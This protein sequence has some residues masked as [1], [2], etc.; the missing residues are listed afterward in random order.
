MT[1]KD[2]ASDSLTADDLD[3]SLDRLSAFA[4]ENNPTARKEILLAKA[5][6]G[7]LEKS[8]RDELFTF[9]GGSDVVDDGETATT[10]GDDL[11]KSMTD[12]SNTDLQEALDVSPY[13]R[14]QHDAMVK[15][16]QSVGDFIEQSDKRQHE[17][18]LM[19]SQALVEMGTLIKGMSVRLGIMEK[20]PARGPKSAGVGTG[21][22][23]AKSFAGDGSGSDGS[24]GGDGQLSKGEIM[25]ALNGLM[26]DSMDGGRNGMTKGGQ[27]ILLSISGFEQSSK[28]SPAM[29]GEVK[30]FIGQQNATH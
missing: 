25:T 22:T 18:S 17:H 30:G 29:F 27:D 10:I 28:L 23:L 14:E 24:G 2:N 20:Q 12:E 15:S 8:E 9:L 26:A 4:E 21:E 5:A 19:Q 16:L 7:S 13:L 1:T 11:V 3:K 6:E